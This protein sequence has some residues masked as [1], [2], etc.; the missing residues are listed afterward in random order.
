[1]N[2]R[3]IG[4]KWEVEEGGREIDRWGGGGEGDMG[5]RSVGAQVERGESESERERERQDRQ[6]MKER[7]MKKE[8]G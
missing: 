1:M 3:E 8:G 6:M 7:K 4:G 2:G 5:E